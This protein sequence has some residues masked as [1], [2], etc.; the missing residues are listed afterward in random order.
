MRRNQGLGP[1]FPPKAAAA[2]ARLHLFVVLAGTCYTWQTN[3]NIA[4]LLAWVLP[5]SLI[6]QHGAEPSDEL[7]GILIPLGR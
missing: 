6:V 4:V 2:H 3:C 5:C 1:D 7:S